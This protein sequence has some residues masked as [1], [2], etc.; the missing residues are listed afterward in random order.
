ME[1]GRQFPIYKRLA[2]KIICGVTIALLVLGVIFNYYL[3]KFH[4]KQMMTSLQNSTTTL[5]K[6]M[7]TSLE[8]AMLERRFD[9][10][11]EQV[12]KL[13]E[14]EGV[15]RILILNRKGEIKIAHDPELL[16]TVINRKDPTCTACHEKA[17]ENRSRTIIFNTEEGKEVFRSVTPVFNKPKCYG[18]HDPKDKI[19]GVLIIDFST[20]KAK[21]L[22]V[23][24]IKTMSLIITLMIAGMISASS[25][26]LTRIITRR[27]RNLERT[28]QT[29]KEGDLDKVIQERGNDEIASLAHHF[30]EM[31]T[32]LRGYIEDSRQQRKYLEN[33]INS[34]DDGIMVIDKDYKIVLANNSCSSLLDK[35]LD[36]IQ[37][38]LCHVVSH[39]RIEPCNDPLCPCPFE[40]T[41][42]TGKHY[43][44]VHTFYDRDG[45]EM[46]I[47]LLTSPLRNESGEIYQVVEV[48]RN[49]TERKQLEAQLIHSERLTSLGI[50]AS[51]LAHELNNP[52]AT[53]ATFIEGLQKRIGEDKGLGKLENISDYTDLVVKETIKCKAIIEKLLLLSRKSEP[54][55][56]IVNINKSL[57]ETLSLA[58]H[59]AIINKIAIKKDL[60]EGLPLIQGDE[61]QIR[62]LFLNMILN[63]VQAMGNGGT[64]IISS[65]GNDQAVSIA[66][67][68]T[69]QGMRGEDMSRI[70]EPFFTTKSKGKGTGLGLTICHNIV[71]LHNGNIKV[72]SVEGK[73]AKF[74][75][76]LPVMIDAIKSVE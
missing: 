46:Q 35:P 63:A 4:N 12:V 9:L 65:E 66:F 59:D 64:L 39:D 38:N 74:T 20:A 11:M 56:D 37:G 54:K 14:E 5:S 45:H 28:A 22:L 42:K 33:L 40:Y 60:G 41:L 8:Y 17:P 76:T 44:V 67:E 24:N 52:L 49:I 6:I 43:K 50:M 19:N 48:L 70:F 47:E 13:K 26:L 72:E 75:V 29:I 53:I 51:G 16:G 3:V 58:E 36:E 25:I 73:G 10:L 2:F 32:S 27:I 34:V 57:E 7:V 30:N 1:E 21:S 55:R 15:E 23:S 61:T 62:Q 31:T 68:D 71:K 69:G 18:C